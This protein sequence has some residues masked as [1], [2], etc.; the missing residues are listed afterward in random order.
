MIIQEVFTN[1][2]GGFFFLFSIVAAVAVHEFM[3]AKTADLLG[4]PT[5]ASMGR[6]TLNPF[7]HLDLMGSI[8][9]LLVG[10]GWGKPV[11]FDPY[12]LDNPKRDAGIIA[13]AGPA[14]NFF[15][16]VLAAVL[17][18]SAVVGPIGTLFVDTF[19][20][21]NIVLGIFNLIPI[22]PLDGFK[23]VG[24]FLSDEQ[25]AQWYSLERYGILFLLFFI[26]PIAGGRSMLE[27]FVLPVI[28][29]LVQLLSTL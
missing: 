27:I 18:P 23:V 9:F 24:A 2:V 21:I 5:P 20:W 28:Q 15:M 6:V 3:H 19:I 25:A 29:N 17:I 4:D 7:A 12:N 8:L 1:P 11:P 14:S 13:I 10:F 16:A 22:A 26:F